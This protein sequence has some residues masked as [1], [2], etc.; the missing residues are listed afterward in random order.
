M[1]HLIPGHWK[2]IPF[3]AQSWDCKSVYRAASNWVAQRI[4]GISQRGMASDEIIWRWGYLRLPWEKGSSG[5]PHDP[6]CHSQVYK[7]DLALKERC[8]T[9]GID[10]FG[11]GR[12]NRA[13]HQSTQAGESWRPTLLWT[14]VSNNFEQITSVSQ[15]PVVTIHASS[16]TSVPIWRTATSN[17]ADVIFPKAELNGKTSRGDIAN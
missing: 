4:Q 14:P 12:D 5:H 11:T 7:T 17:Q 13:V 15:A 2:L 10:G 8:T 16:A 1:D 9:L 3:K 6:T